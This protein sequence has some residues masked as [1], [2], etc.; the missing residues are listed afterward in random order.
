MGKISLSERWK[1]CMPSATL[2]RG[3]GPDNR[4]T[5]IKCTTDG[6]LKV[7]ESINPAGTDICGSGQKNV[8]TAGTAVAIGSSLNVKNLIIIAKCNNLG[9]IFVGNN[10]VSSSTGAIIPPGD[11]LPCGAVNLS[12]IYIDAEHDG[13]GISYYYIR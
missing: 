1:Y 11:M 5:N 10:S 4:P 13:D 2:V 12:T 8:T 7:A 6:Y 3:I 9:D